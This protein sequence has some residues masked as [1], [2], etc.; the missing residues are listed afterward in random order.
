MK[1][2][3]RTPLLLVAAWILTAACGSSS[4]AAAQPANGGGSGAGEP[5]ATVNGTPITKAELDEL[6]APEVSKLEEQAH[7]VRLQGL[8]EI[9]DG[10]LL[11]AEA[12]RRG[13]TREAL[14]RAEIAGKVSPVTDQDVEA[15]IA[16]NRDRLPADPRSIEPQI[17]QYL[18]DQRLAARREA[19]LDE[20]RT[21]ADV[22]VLLKAPPVFRAPIDLTGAPTRGP[23]NA[24]VTLVEFS[25]FHCPFCR[26]VQPTLDELLKKY[27]TQVR[28]V[29]K[30]MPLDSLHPRARRAA[31]ASWCAQQQG[32]FWEYHDALYADPSAG[33]DEQLTAIA[34]R[35]GL[36][37]NAFGACLASDEPKATVQRHVEEGARYGVSGTPGFF[38]NGRL[39]SGA[40]PLESFVRIIEE[41]LAG[42]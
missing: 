24:A 4:G 33:T 20:L 32:R 42:R 14:E 15:F 9:I 25:D 36:D 37:L 12:A 26:R 39:L 35:L 22:K 27:P 1:F 10:R 18:A 23:E 17:R 13:V 16:A 29:Y 38:V 41:E 21:A 30:H 40:Q 7:Q 8:A 6:V 31:E 28:L 34:Q 2:S 11:E 5:V 3:F 19:F